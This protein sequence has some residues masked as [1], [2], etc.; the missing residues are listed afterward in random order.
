MVKTYSKYY[1][2]PITAIQPRGWLG[3]YL[4]T[5]RDGLT[6]HLE[7]AGFPF[8]LRITIFPHALSPLPSGE[9]QG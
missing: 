9:G 4:E 6:G 7:A 1:E 5:Q 3:A 2:L 8:Y